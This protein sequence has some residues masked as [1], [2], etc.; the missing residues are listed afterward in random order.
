MR[1]KELFKTAF[2]LVLYSLIAKVLSLLVRIL[3]AR[4]I[5]EEAMTLYSVASPTMIIMI[6]LA[7]MG[8]PSALSKILADQRLAKK[9]PISASIVISILNNILLTIFFILFVP[10]LSIRIL[11]Q[12]DVLMVLYAI[13]PIIP[14]V[15]M[16]GL[17]K[18]YF[19]GLHQHNPPSIAQIMEEVL[20]AIFLL[21]LFARYDISSPITMAS[22]T[23]L[24]I[25]VG[26]IG[27]LLTLLWYLPKRRHKW[28]QFTRHIRHID[29]PVIDTVLGIS[30]PVTGSRL[31][32]SFTHFL[33]PM[34]LTYRSLDPVAI[35]SSYGQ[36]NGYVLPIITM[37][38]FLT[39]TLSG[40]LLPTFTYQYSSGN[41][42]AAKRT[43]FL[44]SLLCLGLGTA[45]GVIS[46][47]FPHWLMDLLYKKRIAI[48]MLQNLSLPFILYSMQP[49]LSSVLHAMNKSRQSFIDT[50]AG[51]LLRLA[52]LYFLLP[53]GNDQ[54]LLW[55][56]SAGMLCTT[57]LH[58][59]RVAFALFSDD[60]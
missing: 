26:E 50:T 39:L 27:S 24:S 29:K 47:I 53:Y 49:V 52:I 31:I 58:G 55:S 12:G 9:A 13:T 36:L 32:G 18:G 41:T 3:I 7:Q 8:I 51:S 40:W 43:F 1:K 30:L 2:F 48:P 11:K 46:Y 14:L 37:P 35:T 56:L 38:S 5:S 25:A 4:K 42:K 22:I 60:K 54:T 44:I 57:L 59:V 10:L 6:T 16:T 33:E 21:V 28:Q 45:F 34:I 17:L 15:T 20:R 19:I 23:M